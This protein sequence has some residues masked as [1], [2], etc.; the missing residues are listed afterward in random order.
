M[1][2]KLSR[3]NTII[4]LLVGLAGNLAWAIENQFYNVFM[5]KEIAGRPL[6]ISIMVGA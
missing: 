4:I 1:E 5:Y 6:F 3:R 2:E